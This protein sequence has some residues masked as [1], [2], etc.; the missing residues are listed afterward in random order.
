MPYKQQKTFSSK[1]FE[2]NPVNLYFA[3]FSVFFLIFSTGCGQSR[4]Y[5]DESRMLMDTIISIRAY[6][7]DS[8]AAVDRAFDVFSSVEEMASFHLDNSELTALNRSLTIKPSASFTR[9][10]EQAVHYNSFT[11]GYFDPS[12]AVVQKAWGFYDGAGRLPSDDEL[13]KLLAEYTGFTNIMTKALDGSYALASGSLLD[14]GGLAGGHAIELAADILRESGCT[15]FLIDDAGDIWFEGTKPDG[16]RWRVAVRD[17]RDNG[18]LAMIESAVPLAISTSGDY[19]RFV[20]IAGKNYGHIMNPHTGRPVEYYSSVTVVSDS[21]VAADALSTALFAMPPD[22]SAEFC[23]QHGIAALFL[24]KTGN[25]T[26]TE[27]GRPFFT[28]VKAP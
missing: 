13:N 4:Q 3:L 14:F 22:K 9:L 5:H 6:P 18:V 1:H 21:P 7:A 23:R 20:T 24:D 8:S 10:L 16:S 12:F 2:K 26:I 25:I 27:T 11:G 19:E 15:A 17:P 28:Q